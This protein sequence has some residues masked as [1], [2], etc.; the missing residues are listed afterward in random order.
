M[1]DLE[2]SL[3]I[4]LLKAR[5][6]AMARF[7]PMLRSHQ[8][9]EQQWRVLRV[10]A[11]NEGSAIDATTLAERAML[12]APSLS[13]ILQYLEGEGF[14]RRVAD[15]QDQR[16]AYIELTP[17]GRRKFA[18]V[19]PDAE[20]QY[21]AIEARFGRRKLAMLYELLQDFGEA[22]RDDTD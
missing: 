22:M 13:R 15:Q 6:L 17:A 10:L 4:Q 5:E 14:V 9:T 8:L 11:A 12:L 19:G 3:P 21:A 16:R 2:H 1:R 18:A 20:R 7:R